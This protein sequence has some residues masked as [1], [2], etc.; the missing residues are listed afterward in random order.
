MSQ[1]AFWDDIESRRVIQ[2]VVIQGEFTAGEV[3]TLAVVIGSDGGGDEPWNQIDLGLLEA[4]PGSL[5]DVGSS[6]GQVIG[7]D[8]AGPVSFNCFFHLTVRACEKRGRGDIS[9]SDD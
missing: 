9:I 1:V 5:L 6:F 4:G 3:K 8:L 7:R 2:D